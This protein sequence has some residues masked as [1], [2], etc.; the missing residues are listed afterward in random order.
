MARILLTTH[1]RAPAELCFDLSLSI[2]L[3]V[4]ST[5]GTGERAIGGVTSGLIGLGERVTWRA[6]HFGIAFEMTSE[7]TEVRRPR[8][9]QDRMVAGPFAA[10]EHDHAFEEVDGGTLLSD[11]LRFEAPLGPL[12][13][14]VARYVLRPHLTRFLAA[15]NATLKRVAESDGE[16]RRYLRG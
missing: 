14:P 4:D 6:R 2:D 8:F 12:G 1:I 9:F 13:R 5:A 15:R 7:I 10:F 11:D 16:W 3:H